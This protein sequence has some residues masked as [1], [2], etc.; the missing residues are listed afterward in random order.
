MDIWKAAREH[1]ID[2][3]TPAQLRHIIQLWDAEIANYQ[4]CIQNYNEDA[5]RNYGR[6]HL[7]KLQGLRQLFVDQLE[8]LENYEAKRPT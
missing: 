3:Y 6:P 5:M 7:A 2:N 1:K 4:I 8:R